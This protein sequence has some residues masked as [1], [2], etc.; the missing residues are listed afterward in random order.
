MKL[1]IGLV[2][3]LGILPWSLAAQEQAVSIDQEPHHH[4][5]FQNEY[6][7]VHQI[8]L[9]PQEGFKLHKH[10]RD[11]ISVV[12]TGGESIG[13]TPGRPDRQ[14]KSTSGSIGFGQSPR[15]HSSLNIGTTTI[16][17]VAVT[18]LLPQEN[19]RNLCKK[20]IADQPLNCP[21]GPA[22]DA[23]APYVAEPQF[24]TDQT[25]A[26]LTVVRPGK[27]APVG[28]ADR[29]ELVVAI[30]EAVIASADG[31][32]PGKT[33]HPGDFIWI[34]RRNPPRVLKNMSDKPARFATL[35][36]KPI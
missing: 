34:S 31:N 15:V 18:L 28:E 13:H 14:G 12:I 6:V 11:E 36:F 2:L 33:L 23:D 27:S 5:A 7:D 20:Q 19:A 21:A 35:A 25:R 22:A 8:L 10:D 3:L 29:D 16:H 1:K 4:L 17:N 24:E 32:G 26:I 30:D 9:P